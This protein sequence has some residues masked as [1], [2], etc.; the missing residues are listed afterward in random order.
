MPD[1]DQLTKQMDNRLLVL[2]TFSGK[3]MKDQII[4]GNVRLAAAFVDIP[5]FVIICKTIVNHFLEFQKTFESGGNEDIFPHPH[6]YYWLLS[7]PDLLILPLNFVDTF[8]HLYN[9]L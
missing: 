8:C 5:V 7:D 1:V 4:V 3:V 2:K 6:Q 9:S